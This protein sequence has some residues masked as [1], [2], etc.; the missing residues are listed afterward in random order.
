MRGDRRRPVA[1]KGGGEEAGAWCNVNGAGFGVRPTSNTGNS[2][3]DAFCDDTSA[4]FVK[5]A[6]SIQ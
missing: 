4:S 2:L 5:T 1:E 6:S 3:A